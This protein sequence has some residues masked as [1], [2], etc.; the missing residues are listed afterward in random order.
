[1]RKMHLIILMVTMTILL[2]FSLTAINSITYTAYYDIPIYGTDTLGGITYTTVSYDGLNNNV[3]PGMPS[4]P[5]DYIRFSVPYNAT[6]FKV[7]AQ[8]NS[9]TNHRMSYPAY[10]CQQPRMMSDTMPP[11][12][13]LPNSSVY[14][15]GSDYPTQCAWIVD[16]GFLAGDNHIVTVAV[17]PF[18]YKYSSSGFLKHNFKESRNI[19]LTLSYDLSD[20]LALSPIVSNNENSSLNGRHLAQSIVVNPDSVLNFAP[21][22]TTYP[23]YSPYHAPSLNLGL[24]PF[25]YLIITTPDLT[26]SLRRLTALKMQKGYNVKMA[27]VDEIM[28]DPYAQYGDVVYV[29]GTPTV[30]FDDSVGV[31]R[32]YLKL[33]KWFFGT[34]YLLLVGSNVPYRTQRKGTP[35]GTFDVPTDLY[36]SDLNGNWNRNS[37]IDLYPELFVGRLSAK[38]TYQ[39]DNYTDKLLRYELNPGRGNYA[40]L[41]KSLYTESVGTFDY[42]KN[43]GQYMNQIYP[44]SMI[45]RERVYECYPTGRDV[46]NLIN[47]N[48]YAFWCA[49][50]HGAPSCIMTYGVNIWNHLYSDSYFF[51]HAIDSVKIPPF[52]AQD[53][54]INNGLNRIENSGYEMILYSTS[55]ETMPFDVEP[56]YLSL[57]MNFGESFIMGENYGGPAYL[58]NTRD[59]VNPSSMDLC[60]V[61]AKDLVEYSHKIG[62]AEALSKF[63]NNDEVFGGYLAMTHNLLGDP[64]FEIWTDT[65]QLYTN[66]DIMRTD[67]SISINGIDADSTIVAYYSNDGQIGTDTISSSS[68]VLNS[69]SPNSTV[70]LYKHNYI[71]YIAPLDLQNITFSNNQYVIASDVNAGSAIDNNRTNGSVIV[72]DGIEYEIEASGKV[73]LEDGFKVDKGATFAVYPACF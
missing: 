53:T 44:D 47:T 69:V 5:V 18:V 32:E 17:M 12:I 55:C 45:I 37:T 3:D 51:L 33:S 23:T 66:I 15:S 11:V 8:S 49:F 65:P 52:V 1:M 31:I 40:Y 35:L 57:P 9:T 48:R 13:T 56:K 46:I 64:E 54:E 2:P 71:P 42:S 25:P 39:I 43:I 58:G 27:T 63:D 26:H 59:G 73:T 50:N 21:P 61:F 20:T 62:V 41:K 22:T 4:L 72:P 60:S 10:P 38:N 24:T 29:N 36:F 19:N 30:T 68:V 7:S 67:N 28:N 6:N 16:E 14:Y 34:E 70:M